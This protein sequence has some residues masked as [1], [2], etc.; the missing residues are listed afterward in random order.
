MPDRLTSS[1]WLPNLV[2]NVEPHER[3]ALVLAFLCN[4]V[5]LGSYYILRPVRDAMATV[6]GVEQLQNLFT[7]T[8]V[9]TLL[10][11]PVFAWLTDTFKLSR[12]LPGV[13]WF[14]ILDLLG[15]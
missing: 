1:R 15:F 9:L 3:K 10:C 4:F 7:G 14:L 2:A 12:V 5:L 13:F 8:L 6:F 11:S